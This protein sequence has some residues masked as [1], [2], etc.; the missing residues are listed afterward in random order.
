[1]KINKNKQLI[2]AALIGFL[3]FKYAQSNTISFDIEANWN[4]ERVIEDKR[5]GSSSDN[6]DW[7]NIDTEI[8]ST[9]I[10]FDLFSENNTKQTQNEHN[11]KSNGYDLAWWM[12]VF[13]YTAQDIYTPFS[14]ELLGL[15]NPDDYENID[16]R[17]QIFAGGTYHYNDP[18]SDL[19]VKERISFRRDLSGYTRET[20]DDGV[21]Q[22][23][24]TY[25]QQFTIDLPNPLSFDTKSYFDS[26]S[27]DEILENLSGSSVKFETY[28]AK[29]S[30]WNNDDYSEKSYKS[31]TNGY[32]GYG[33]Y[34]YQ[35]VQSV[36]EPSTLTLFLP[37]A[38][39]CYSL[40]KRQLVISL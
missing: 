32:R 18:E 3:P 39:I 40:R 29:R 28:V 14:T 31:V 20:V 19:D 15:V 35:S 27:T 13:N 26:Y 30:W 6:T 17:Y 36:P 37:F 38:L 1:M 2:I 33:T 25:W 16:D 23:D 10:D 4:Y 21:I 5:D 7:T 12:T 9:Q 11:F 34:N 22:N 8:F 24:F